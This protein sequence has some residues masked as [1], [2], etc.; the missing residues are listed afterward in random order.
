M[1]RDEDK[2]IRQ[3]S[4]LSFLLSRPRPF[5]ARE[6]QE[7]VE[8]YAEMSDETFARRFFGDR[9]DLAKVGLEIRAL[10]EAPSGDMAGAQLYFL[11]AEDFRLP[12]VEFTPAESRALA[13]ALAA[14]D[15]RFAYAR[16]L[17]LALTAILRGRGEPLHT[18]LEQLPVALAPDEDAQR[19]GRQLSRLEEAVTRGKTVC[20]AYPSTG[21]G[22][23]ERTLDP[24]SLY[25]IQGHWY[26]VGHDRLRDG[27]RTFRVGRIQG[28]VRFLTE[29][30]RD[31]SIPA[32]YDPDR[33]RARPPWLI[34]AVSGTAVVRAG[35]ELSWWVKRLEPHVV[36]VGEE[37]DGCSLFSFP[38]AD[39]S[40][41]LSWL[42]GSGGCAELLEPAPLRARLREALSRVSSAHTGPVT[43]GDAL[44]S[45]GRPGHATRRAE[46]TAPIAAEHLARAMALLR[47]LVDSRRPT[48]VTWEE[49]ERDLG[50][51]RVEVESDLSLI[52]LMNF[53]GGTYTLMAEAEAE[54]VRAV[55]DVMA[56]TFAQPA[57]L[58]PVMARALLL[59]L[60]LLGDTI[61]L[62]G[63]ESL[64]SVREKVCALIGRDRPEGAV[65][66]DD[67]V[68]AAPEV[69][70]VLNHAVRDH[71]VVVLEYFTAAREEL[72][73]RPVEPYLLF[74]S[75]DG[76]YLEAFCL[77]AEAQRTFKLE[78]VRRAVSTETRF[79]P[80]PEI[81]LARRRTGQAF[82]PDGV[83]KW[84]T[85]C[86]EPR[87]QTYLN[88][89][90]IEYVTLP[91]GRLRARIPYLDECWMAHEIV[92]Y[93]GDA[94]LE[95]PVSARQRVQALATIL[96]ERY[97]QPRAP[98]SATA[99]RGDDR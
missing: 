64:D 77:K 23:L 29:K 98:G 11:A 25:L 91:D 65:I 34:G 41:L 94:V 97:D 1:G 8:G 28:T 31:F 27:I 45:A 16:P 80:R 44:A 59:A 63:L 81:D 83:A 30:A 58:S 56:D 71:R 15:G 39:D 78:R 99:R 90:R 10:N 49:L 17:R 68:P 40:V 57:R 72:S 38:Y 96:A 36:F 69:V 6:I 13:L 22:S 14:L 92:R 76:W 9:A 48:L 95:Q 60:D 50:L 21:G 62:E 66:V 43:G 19:A 52:N 73:E 24:Y 32:D 93:L 37:D 20:F 7:S 54:G 5:T 51:S 75:A 46:F 42:A 87:W 12:E 26:V 53:G 55:P 2:L 35:E 70:D 74:R 4:L 47:Y 88:E 33:Y 82:L 89:S 61:V 3:L 79:T 84:A 67:M 18:E 86:F 85:V